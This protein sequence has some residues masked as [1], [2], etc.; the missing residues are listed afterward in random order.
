MQE[1]NKPI[2]YWLKK[3]DE[4]L[5]KGIANLHAQSGI[6]RI[7][8]QILRFLKGHESVARAELFHTL[9]PFADSAS[10][11]TI[12]QRLQKQ[13]VLQEQRLS[14]CLTEKG[15]TLHNACFERQKEFRQQSMDGILEQEYQTTI[16]TLAKLVA[17]LEKKK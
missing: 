6:T 17:N 7:E 3:A 10:L 13:G 5:T 4:V 12:V 15:H 16:A 11:E 14:V 2:G 1:N 8:W 9:Q